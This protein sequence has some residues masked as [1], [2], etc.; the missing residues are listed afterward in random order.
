MTTIT[1]GTTT[2]TPL[3]ILRR[4]H[5]RAAGTI[6]HEILGRPDPDVS[7]APARTR[8]GRHRIL[9]SDYAHAMEC[10]ALHRGAS[11]LV[12]DDTD[13]PAN[14]MSYVVSGDITLTLDEQTS[15]RVIVEVEYREVLL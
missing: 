7:L 8:R 12:L 5:T 13:Q 4:E 9:F 2:V 11:V 15:R 10:D 1:D 14:S 3:L 6:V